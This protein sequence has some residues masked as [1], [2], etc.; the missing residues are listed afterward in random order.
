VRH[1]EE[2]CL[3]WLPQVHCQV[4]PHDA[5]AAPQNKKDNYFGAPRFYCVETICAPCGAV[6]AWTL[7]DKAESETR[8]LEF[9]EAVYPTPDL[10][11]NYVC[12]DTAC[13][14]LCMAISNGAWNTWKE[15]TWFIVDSYHYINHHTTDYPR[16]LTWSPQ[17]VQE[18][19]WGSVKYRKTQSLIP[20]VPKLKRQKLDILYHEQRQ[21][22]SKERSDE[23]WS[24]YTNIQKLNKAKK[25]KFVGGLQG[26]QAR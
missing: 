7:F 4:Q 17:G 6:I 11:P 14:V 5:A 9:L 25:T 3:P 12:I 26:L 2:E 24:T 21:L 20:S 16:A 23:F 19:P 22:Q 10:Q 18:D 1:S 15:T 13:R 8:I